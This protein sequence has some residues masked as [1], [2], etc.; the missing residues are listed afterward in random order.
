MAG[1][2]R[3]ASVLSLLAVAP[4]RAQELNYQTY[5]IGTRA[6]GMGGAFTG[7]ADDP[8]TA[9]HN[10]AGLGPMLRS[11]TSANLSVIAIEG[12]TMD[13]GYGGLLGPADLEHDA[14]P[15]LPL[16]VGFVQK[17]GAE[18][19]DGIR[20]Q[21]LALS[22]VRPGLVRRRFRVDALEPGRGIANTLRVQHEDSAQWYGL[23]YGIRLRQGLALGLGTWL[24]IR[25]L[26]HLEEEFVAEGIATVDGLRTADRFVARYSEA[27]VDSFDFVFR[28]GLLWQIDAQWRLGVMFQPAPV[29]LSTRASISSRLGRASAGALEDLRFVELDGLDGNLPTP[30]QLRV[31][32]GHRVAP[33]LTFALDVALYAPMGL[34]A[35]IR[36]FGAT[37]L[38]PVTGEPVRPGR[39]LPATWQ[40]NFTANVSVGMDAL[41]A[42]MVPLQ[43]GLFTDLSAAPSIDGPATEYR[44]PQVHGFGASVAGGLHRGEFDVQVGVAGVFGWGTGLGTSPDPDPLSADRYVP[45]DVRRYTLYVFISGTERAAASLVRELLEE[46]GIAEPAPPGDDQPA[47]RPSDGEARSASEDRRAPSAP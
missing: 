28:V 42:D 15:S 45:R 4:A 12:W 32:V 46:M 27:G 30:W 34:G 2:I 9:F 36:T 33:E 16:F 47:P 25:Q 6:M 19:S 31:G 1:W 41:I 40:A 3:A 11:S 20:Q 10:P 17:F 22:I 7:V 43:V 23:S 24:S 44:A 18:G 35:P 8:S 37:E 14:I 13:G 38:D 29:S 39:F 26:R 5:L 21:G